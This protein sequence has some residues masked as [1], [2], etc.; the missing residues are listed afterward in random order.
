M[1]AF[2]KAPFKDFL[3]ST[4]C[5]ERNHWKKIGKKIIILRMLTYTKMLLCVLPRESY[6]IGYYL[7]DINK[8]LLYNKCFK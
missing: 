1:Q 8:Q 4:N 3:G 5:G 2:F 7:F 6:I